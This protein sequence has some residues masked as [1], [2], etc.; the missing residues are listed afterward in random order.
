MFRAVVTS[1]NQ[2]A[3]S[4]TLDNR[5]KKN[6]N[7][8]FQN[9][10]QVKSVL[11]VIQLSKSSFKFCSQNIQLRFLLQKFNF[12]INNNSVNFDGIAGWYLHLI[13]STAVK[14]PAF[15]IVPCR[16][17]LCVNSCRVVERGKFSK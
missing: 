3:L 1:S 13:L 8:N 11:L 9:L 4:F 16:T 17:N 15:Q 14:S 10:S 5:A 6:P 2:K 12:N 7:I